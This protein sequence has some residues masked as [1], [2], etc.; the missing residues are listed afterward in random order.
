MIKKAR[1]GDVRM[2]HRMINASAAKGEILPRSLM[3]L[4]GSLRDFYVYLDKEGGPIVGICAMHI[5]WENLAE[6][7]SLFVDDA[8][9]RKG[10]GRILVEACISEA[11]TLEIY[12]VFSLT[13]QREFFRSLNFMEVDRSTLPEK[14]WSDCFKCPKYPDFCD[15]VAMILEL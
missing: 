13:Y 7:R 15:E 2:M 1:V 3:D 14:I 11:I 9:R 5:F 12:R 8:Y 10:I 4:Y 6:I